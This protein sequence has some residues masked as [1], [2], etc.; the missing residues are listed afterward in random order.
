MM[1]SV[2]GGML[3]VTLAA[4]GAT[5]AGAQET[6][7]PVFE[8][9][10]RPFEQHEF[11][12]NLS[13]PGG[14]LSY[15]LEGFYRFGY[16]AFDIGV[17]GGWAKIQDS[18]P[19]RALL[20]ADARTRVISYSEKFPFDGAVTLGFGFNIGSGL[21]D[22][23]YLPIGLSLGRRFNLEGSQTTFV[24]FVHPVLIPTWVSGDSR[25]DASLG[26]GVD[27]RFGR[28]WAARLSGGLGDVDGVSVGLAYER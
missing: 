3:A 16:E 1:R 26:F 22:Q 5:T 2:V 15:A 4:L 12:A 8:A 11:G 28:N 9:P 25:V 13:A 10:Y 7:T 24:P 21:P 17:R 27:I 23:Y 19:T 18:G 20:G 6:G 14:N